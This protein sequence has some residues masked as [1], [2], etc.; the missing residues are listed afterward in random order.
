MIEE[1]DLFGVFLPSLFVWMILA[2]LATLVLRRLLSSVGAYH[3]IWHRPLFDISLYVLTLGTV[4]WTARY[5][6]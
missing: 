3:Y 2:F 1:I 6:A 5:L 4:I